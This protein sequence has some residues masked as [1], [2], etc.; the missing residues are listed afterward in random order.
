M[1]ESV[2]KL[3]EIF[4]EINKCKEEI[5]LKIL[6]IFTKIR[7]MI[8]EREDQLLMNQIIFLIIHFLKKI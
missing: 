5:K 1:E 7:N 8:N 2:Q 3:K 6:N 4:K